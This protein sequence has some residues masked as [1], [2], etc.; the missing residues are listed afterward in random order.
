M[1][2]VMKYNNFFPLS[3]LNR[4]LFLFCLLLIFNLFFFYFFLNKLVII[5]FKNSVNLFFIYKIKNFYFEKKNF[6]LKKYI[7]YYL[8][9][10]F[11][12]NKYTKIYFGNSLLYMN[13]YN[14][15]FFILDKNFYLNYLNFIK[16][17]NFFDLGLIY[18]YIYNFF[19]IIWFFFY[20]FKIYFLNEF[21]ILNIFK[22]KFLVKN[23]K[24]IKYIIK[25]INIEFYFFIK[26]NFNFIKNINIYFKNRILDIAGI[27]HDLRMPLTRIIL[28]IEII[29]KNYL[30]NNFIIDIKKDVEECNILI[31]CF[32]D[33]INFNKK[34]KIRYEIVNFNNLVNEVINSKIRIINKIKI[35]LIDKNLNVRLNSF[36]IKRVICN[37]LNN[38]IM[39]GNNYIIVSSGFSKKKKNYVWLK[40]EDNGL[41]ISYKDIDNLFKPF[42]RGVSLLKNKNL[43]NFGKGLGLSIIKNIII[44]YHNGKIK[45][46]KSKIGGFLIKFYL[47]LF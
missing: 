38:S 34:N 4:S 32:L 36:L 46:G 26:K 1:E 14:S 30:K 42:T 18:I 3:F 41:G 47:P 44:N 33:Y 31:D 45:T 6:I 10:L 15:Y 35:S 21:N 11:K 5:L 8:C 37:I 7:I 16:I 12:Y 43:N 23:Y 40:I 24:F 28:S 29:E 17:K 13:I 2:V 9:E 25:I 27:S 39:Y 19:F 20:I 22:L